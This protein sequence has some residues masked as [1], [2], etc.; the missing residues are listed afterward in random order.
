[1]ILAPSAGRRPGLARPAAPPPARPPRA[2]LGAARAPCAARTIRRPGGSAQR[3]TTDATRGRIRARRRLATFGGTANVTIAHQGRARGRRP[4]RVA[5]RRPSPFRSWC[6]H[7]KQGAV[8]SRAV[9]WP[10]APRARVRRPQV[11]HPTRVRRLTRVE[12]S[13]TRLAAIATSNRATTRV[14]APKRPWNPRRFETA[15]TVLHRCPP[16][17][18]RV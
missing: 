3:R 8:H 5:W 1:V 16:R 13:S 12:P 14:C 18:G 15:A 10:S 9:G 17:G 4:G 2:G 7:A 6:S 11:A